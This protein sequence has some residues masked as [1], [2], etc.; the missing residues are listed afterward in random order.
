MRS[1]SCGFRDCISATQTA[2]NKEAIRRVVKRHIGEIKFCYEKELQA[3][4]KL[5]GRVVVNFVVA[6]DG[7]VA[8]AK[9]KSSDLKS[10]PV[11]KCVAE[12]IKK[13]NFPA[14]DDGGIQVVN[15][16]FMFSPP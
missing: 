10:S 7:G 4:P 6:G 14:P 5:T 2:T 8:S 12:A 1:H 13:W 9:V 3:Q 15:Y 16:P 11:E